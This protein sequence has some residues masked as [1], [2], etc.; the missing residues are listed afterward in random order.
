[1]TE[2]DNAKPSSTITRKCCQGQR[3]S[4]RA[5]E[6]AQRLDMWDPYRFSQWY[7]WAARENSSLPCQKGMRT[8]WLRLAAGISRR[9]R[10][11]AGEGG[12]KE[13][14]CSLAIFAGSH[15]SVKQGRKK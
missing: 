5:G 6:G 3:G 10:G 4:M 8:G 14:T 15:L 13:E 9:H 12:V 7:A 2:S 11:V 1:M